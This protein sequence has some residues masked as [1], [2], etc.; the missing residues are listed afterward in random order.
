MASARKGHRNIACP[1][2]INT[3]V[4]NWSNAKTP[5]RVAGSKPG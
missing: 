2:S 1:G 5:T 3:D 4:N